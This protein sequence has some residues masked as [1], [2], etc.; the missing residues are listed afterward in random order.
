MQTSKWTK[1][2]AKYLLFL[3]V[4]AVTLIGLVMVKDLR[5]PERSILPWSTKDT[6]M[7][8]TIYTSLPPK[9]MTMDGK[10]I[11]VP[12]SSPKIFELPD[13]K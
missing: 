7:A 5:Q 10:L 1:S 8:S 13:G 11:P 9:C 3:A 2:I 6:C 4:M 12:G